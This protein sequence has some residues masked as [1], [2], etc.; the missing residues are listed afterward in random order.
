MDC[1]FGG[2]RGGIEVVVC[3]ISGVLVVGLFIVLFQEE[4]MNYR[5]NPCVS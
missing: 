3:G 1:I 5:G 2:G 4:K